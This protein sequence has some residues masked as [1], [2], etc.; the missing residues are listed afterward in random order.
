MGSK[1]H[2]ANW[3]TPVP[4][5]R[6]RGEIREPVHPLTPDGRG[7][8]IDATQCHYPHPD[9]LDY[10]SNPEAPIGTAILKTG[11]VIEVSMPL[12]FP[13]GQI[14]GYNVFHYRV[15]IPVNNYTIQ[16]FADGVMEEWGD[17]YNV[18]RFQARFPYFATGAVW[19]PCHVRNLS[20]K[21]VEANADSSITFTD[22]QPTE[23][24]SLRSAFLVRKH[25]AV[26]GK[27][28][29]GRFLFAPVSENGQTAGVANPTALTE[30]ERATADIANL[31]D[32]DGITGVLAILVI[33]N[34]TASKKSGTIQTTVGKSVSASH[35]LSSVRDRV[36]VR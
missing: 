34:Q 5:E 16:Q 11:D 23:A 2:R 12:Q 30:I 25:T 6:P 27:T 19:G 29:H 7:G 24:I 9:Q 31:V 35:I 26:E 18:T 36:R 33:Y 28:G 1:A 8:F 15:T 4:F 32:V 14:F 20:S 17:A 21:G 3:R 10:W 22:P 13:A